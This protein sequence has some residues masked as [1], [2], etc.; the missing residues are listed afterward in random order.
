MQCTTV[1]VCIGLNKCSTYMVIP[2]PNIIRCIACMQ[3]QEPSVPQGKLYSTVRMKLKKALFTKLIPILEEH[4]SPTYL[5][6]LGVSKFSFCSSGQ[7]DL[8]DIQN[9][10]F[11][12]SMGMWYVSHL[13]C[14]KSLRKY[15]FYY[16]NRVL[17]NL[18]RRGLYIYKHNY[19]SESKFKPTFFNRT[20]FCLFHVQ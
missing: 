8:N 20:Q 17:S 15:A 13:C 3:E 11:Q 16:L 14:A 4:K 2:K 19:Y 6:V 1:C 12:V 7:I 5:Q 18:I 9:K 10:G